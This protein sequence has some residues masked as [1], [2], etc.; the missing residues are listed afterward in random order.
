MGIS[1]RFSF[2]DAVAVIGDDISGD[3][4]VKRGRGIQLKLSKYNP[5]PVPHVSR[6]TICS[7]R[8]HLENHGKG[9]PIATPQYSPC[10]SR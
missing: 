7:R 3:L 1:A 6:F 5:G 8:P 2:S 9:Y 4:L 10:Y